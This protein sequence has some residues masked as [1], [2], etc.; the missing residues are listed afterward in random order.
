MLIYIIVLIYYSKKNMRK[1]NLIL[2]V[3][4]IF[5][6]FETYSYSVAAPVWIT[7]PY[8]RAGN[9]KLISSRTGNNTTP[10]F[11]FTFSSSLSGVP[12]LAYGIKNYRGDKFS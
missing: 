11:T 10:T 5:L 4:Y 1:V 9:Q 12:N 7:S 3:S 8:F 6:L 2:W